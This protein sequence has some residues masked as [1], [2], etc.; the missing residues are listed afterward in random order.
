ME[1][2]DMLKTIIQTM[3]DV[4]QSARFHARES[5]GNF[6]PNL[7]VYAIDASHSHKI[8][9]IIQEY[10]YP[11]TKIIGKRGMKNW[12]LLVQHQDLDLDIQKNVSSTVIF[13]P[14]NMLILQTAC[15]LILVKPNV[16]EPN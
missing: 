7:L 8:R 11:T 3:V 2:R 16:M 5:K 10:G 13:H 12:W 1:Q 14:K 15:S 6:P 4:D 9:T